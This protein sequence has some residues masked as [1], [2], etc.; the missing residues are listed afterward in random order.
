MNVRMIDTSILLNILDVPDRNQ[1]REEVAKEFRMLINNSSE[2]L[3]LPLATIIETG[4]H[5]AHIKNG[6]MRREKAELMAE[7]LTKTANGNAPWEYFGK[8]LDKEDLIHIAQ[9]FP[10][11]AMGG[12]G[13]GDLSIIRAYEKYKES[14]PGIG[15]IMI[16]SKDGHLASYKEDMPQ[17][18][19]R[20]NK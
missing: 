12:T 8:E 9:E 1:H 4:N 16:W 15:T 3:I 11:S 2:T 5:I 17:H 13:I 14:V 6:N 7:Y 18:K 20:K 19:R 10:G